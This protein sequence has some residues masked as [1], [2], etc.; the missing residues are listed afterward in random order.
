[1]FKVMKSIVKPLVEVVHFAPLKVGGK[2]EFAPIVVVEVI[3]KGTHQDTTYCIQIV[4][5]TR[6]SRHMS[7]FLWKIV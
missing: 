6:Q 1:M 5:K 7:H 4:H 2:D 3:Y